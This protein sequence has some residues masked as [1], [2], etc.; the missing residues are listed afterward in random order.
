MNQKTKAQNTV[1]PDLETLLN[2]VDEL[3][4]QAA[5]GHTEYSTRSMLK[6]YLYMLVKRIKGFKTLAK[7]LRLKEE[8]LGK[9]SLT[10]C[11]HRTILSRRFKQLP[12]VLREQVRSIHAD[13]VAENVTL[14]EAM[15]VDFS[16]MHAQGNVW[17]KKQR[18]KGESPKCGNIDIE[19]HWGK[20]G[21][22][23]WVYGYRVHCLVSGCTAAALPCDVDVA[24][25]NIKDAKVFKDQLA[26]S[27]PG[28]TQVL[29][30][31]GGFDDH[32]VT[33]ET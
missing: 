21:C 22:G 7:Q 12:L 27:I 28:Q 32:D 26:S 16:L 19:A 31:D 14:V 17:H 10:S 33:P 1:T 29:L 11:P 5:S 9:F 23:T 3:E 18:D 13:F 15:S 4:L 25:A 20:S 24:P 8:L 30:G 6:L 2:M